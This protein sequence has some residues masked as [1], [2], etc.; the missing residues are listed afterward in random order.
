VNLYFW[1]ER[2]QENADEKD[3]ELCNRYQET[4]CIKEEKVLRLKFLGWIKE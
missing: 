2:K 4:I 1:K 3:V